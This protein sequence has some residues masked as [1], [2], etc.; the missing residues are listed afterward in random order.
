MYYY[1]LTINSPL[2]LSLFRL[3]EHLPTLLTFSVKHFIDMIQLQRLLLTCI[4]ELDRYMPL[5]LLLI[6][7]RLLLRSELAENKYYGKVQS[8]TFKCDIQTYGRYK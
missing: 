3:D 8:F 7:L 6:Q 2:F 5:N 1:I 4:E